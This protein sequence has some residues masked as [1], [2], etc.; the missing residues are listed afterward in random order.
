MT[1]SV[2]HLTEADLDDPKYRIKP[3]QQLIASCS[4]ALITSVFGK[5]IPFI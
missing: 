4:G 1:N 3:Y 2:T 5:D